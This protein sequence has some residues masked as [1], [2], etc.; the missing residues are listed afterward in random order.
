MTILIK[1]RDLIAIVNFPLEIKVFSG[2]FAQ[3]DESKHRNFSNI[4]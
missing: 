2:V 4:H 1:C 3:E